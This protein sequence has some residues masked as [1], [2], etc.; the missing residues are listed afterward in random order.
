MNYFKGV[1]IGLGTVLLGCL[2]APVAFV[3][4]AIMIPQVGTTTVNYSVLGLAHHLARSLSFWIFVLVL[5]ALGFVPT[6]F[7]R[8]R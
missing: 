4:R 3:I 1:L 5:F 2:V 8:R 7:F 6:V